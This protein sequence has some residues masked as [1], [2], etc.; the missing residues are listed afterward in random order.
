MNS[1]EKQKLDEEIQGL[2]NRPR[3]PKDDEKL[4]KPLWTI[5]YDMAHLLGGEDWRF[6]L[7]APQPW[8]ALL[9]TFKLDV[10]VRNGGFHQFFWNSEGVGNAAVKEDLAF[11]GASEF[12]RIFNEAVACATLFQVV[13]TKQRGNNT[14][15]EF[16]AGYK[17]IPW[18]AHD[19]AYYETSPT[20]FQQVARFV[21]ANPDA[22]KTSA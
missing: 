10:Q 7:K 2:R 13:E 21:R 19:R 16:T 9:T 8:R 6:V 1:K 4:L 12:L 14:W 3:T 17:S 20:L 15:E 22:F 18:D 11:F 5:A